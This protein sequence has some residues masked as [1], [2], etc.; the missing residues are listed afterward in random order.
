M[1]YLKQTTAQSIPL[2]NVS[3]AKQVQSDENLDATA[4][5]S[6]R[7]ARSRYGNFSL[8]DGGGWLLC[9]GKIHLAKTTASIT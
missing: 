7:W 4:G 8:S 2:T 6:R 1:K 9:G 5:D 3:S